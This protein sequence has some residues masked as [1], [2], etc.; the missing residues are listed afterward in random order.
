MYN[1]LFHVGMAL[2]RQRSGRV[3]TSPSGRVSRH[4]SILSRIAGSLTPPVLSSN[5][6]TYKVSE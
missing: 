3:S 4:N 5:Q 2:Q 6:R 1:F